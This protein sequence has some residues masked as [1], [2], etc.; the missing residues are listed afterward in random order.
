MLQAVVVGNGRSTV[1]AAREVENNGAGVRCCVDFDGGAAVTV[2][3][4]GVRVVLCCVDV[5]N[6]QTERTEHKQRKKD[7]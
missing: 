3:G 1:P 2:A 5:E 6:N 7:R 4:A